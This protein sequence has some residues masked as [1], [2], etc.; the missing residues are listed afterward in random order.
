MTSEPQEK[1]ND[2][3]SKRTCLACGKDFALDVQ[4]CPADGSP[5]TTLSIDPLI[6]SFFAERY[7]I[8]KMLG[9]GGMSSV[10]KAKHIL[11]DRIVAIK[12]L[13][14][15]DV[16]SLKRFQL[17]A[18]LVS[19][20]K[21]RN[22]VTV[23]DFGVSFKGQPYLVMDYLEGSNLMEEIRKVKRLDLARAVRIFSQA[24]EALM[25]AHKREVIHR[26]LKPSNFM[27]VEEEDIVDVVKL[28]DFGI[29][30]R[31]TMTAQEA[32][33]LTATG[34]I[35]GSPLYMSPE[36]CMGH[37]LDGRSDIYSLGCVMY[38]AL[39]GKPPLL[40]SNTMDTLQRH[41]HETPPAFAVVDPTLTSIPKT[42]EKIVLK[43][44]QRDPD[45][46][47][48]T[49]SQLLT[50]LENFKVSLNASIKIAAA[51]TLS[52]FDSAA[53]STK[54]ASR[55]AEA[56]SA[57]APP[58]A[59]S[60]DGDTL[61]VRPVGGIASNGNSDAKDGRSPANGATAA[62]T[63]DPSSNSAATAN[64]TWDG[65]S[66]HSS[67]KASSGANPHATANGDGF[68]PSG[69]THPDIKQALVQSP[70]SAKTQRAKADFAS[71]FSAP[72][73]TKRPLP[74]LAWAPVI[75]A[76]AT[77]LAALIMF[78]FFYPKSPAPQIALRST[79]W[80]QVNDE[81]EKEF[82]LGHYMKAQKLFERACDLSEDY[83]AQDPR[84][85]TSLNNLGNVY[86]KQDFYPEAERTIKKLID[87]QRH[88]WTE[89]LARR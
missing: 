62:F 58:G 10:Y 3:D 31:L 77:A 79:V 65:V 11:M 50:E 29:A 30:K 54:L 80:K 14:A 35:L 52:G 74:K 82:A 73:K 6:G 46:R 21:H 64:R 4:F 27:L 28:V 49:V 69:Q 78:Y 83:D 59:T 32:E 70:V 5:L 76:L 8:L 26:D 71:G 57:S 89:W 42:I 53:L 38:E 45:E 61:V 2:S 55:K 23:Y 36:Q 75:A 17:E 68:V 33:Q 39:T 48:Q 7:Q 22:I 15:S 19:N 63:V 37:R 1:Q 12:I 41:I 25:Y 85:A 9:R 56:A 51:N 86:F 72:Y 60:I 84:Y 81:G 24:C 13:V 43:C 18:K 47:Y 40:G 67:L 20:L 66:A 87:P 16:P 44:L 88:F 34:Q